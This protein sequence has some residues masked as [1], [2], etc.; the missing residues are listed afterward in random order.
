MNKKSFIIGLLFLFCTLSYVV[1]MEV[2]YSGTIDNNK[3]IL[4]NQINDD[5]KEDTKYEVVK[6]K[7]SDDSNSVIYL[8][9]VGLASL[10]L[11]ISVSIINKKNTKYDS[12]F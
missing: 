3:N 9:A 11:V 2:S 8:G 10:I 4:N 5:L 7:Y 12:T 6:K 1:G